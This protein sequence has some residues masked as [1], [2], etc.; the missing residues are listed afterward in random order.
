[1]TLQIARFLFWL[2]L[3]VSWLWSLGALLYF[4]QLSKPARV[5]LAASWI[6][7]S[8]FALIFVPVWSSKIIFLLAGVFLIW[9]LLQMFTPQTE[10]DW[11]PEQEQ[12]AIATFNKDNTVTIQNIRDWHYHKTPEEIHWIEKSYAPAGII[13]ADYIVVPFA[14]WRGIAHVFITFGFRNGEHLAVSVEARR[15]R[16][17]EYS[18]LRGIYNN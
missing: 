18:P 15:Q 10:R 16:G 5:S 9:F 17:T 3:P 8:L 11:T 6:I 14:K 12:T 2:C 1:M 4:P 7:L 13:S